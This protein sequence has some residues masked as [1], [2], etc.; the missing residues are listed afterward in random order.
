M[1]IVKVSITTRQ[2]VYEMY[3]LYLLL[4]IYRFL[5]KPQDKLNIKAQFTITHKQQKIKLLQMNRYN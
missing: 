3:F 4:T 2:D 1:A 5:I